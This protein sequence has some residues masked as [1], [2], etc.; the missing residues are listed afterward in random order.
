MDSY[1]GTFE[2][3]DLN[4]II[5]DHRYQRDLKPALVAA[6]ATDPRWELFG[7]PVLFKRQNGMFYVADGQQRLTGLKQSQNPPQKVPV[8]WFPVAGLDDEAAAFVQINEF[9]KSLTALEKHKGKIVA[10]E[11]STLAIERAV[12]T[13][14][15][16]IGGNAIGGAGDS[17]TISAIAALY[18]IYNNLGE[19]GLIQT[20]VVCRDAW[21]NDANAFS[22]YIL[23][24][25]AEII[26]EQNGSYERQ[27][28]TR[29]LQKT[30]VPQVLR[31]A[32]AFRFDLGGSKQKNVRRAFKQLAKV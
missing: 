28:L 8:V 29:A 30:S 17:R 31:Q 2:L 26:A 24:G 19:E 5:V 15:L 13:A 25:V 9:R 27:R 12:E 32:D 23:R 14:G 3:V 20:L 1:T 16:S 18:A 7:V 4:A 6:I 11:P 10:K 21:E 22:T